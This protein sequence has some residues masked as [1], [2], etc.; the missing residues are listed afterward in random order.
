M[1]KQRK[2]FPYQIHLILGLIWVVI[3]ITFYSGIASAIWIGGG[4][5][6]I[7]IGFLNRK[8]S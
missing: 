2:F 8:R 3:G 4:L 6:M 1:K 7:I 5:T